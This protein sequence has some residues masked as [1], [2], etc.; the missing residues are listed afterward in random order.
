MASDARPPG[1]VEIGLELRLGGVDVPL[2]E[3]DPF[4]Q[5]EELLRRPPLLLVAQLRHDLVQH[6]VKTVVFRQNLAD[7]ALQLGFLLRD[8]MLAKLPKQV[9]LEDDVGLDHL[10][11]EVHRDSSAQQAAQLLTFFALETF[12]ERLLL[13]LTMARAL[14][15][16]VSFRGSV[17]HPA[18]S[19]AAPFRRVGD[20]AFGPLL[21]GECLPLPRVLLAE[22]LEDLFRERVLLKVSPFGGEPSGTD[23]AERR[24]AGLGG[25][26]EAHANGIGRVGKVEP[27]VLLRALERVHEVPFPD[28]QGAC[29]P[30]LGSAYVRRSEEGA[31]AQHGPDAVGDLRIPD[32]AGDRRVAAL[33]DVVRAG[34]L[35]SERSI[36][37][38]TVAKTDFTRRRGG[39]DNVLEIVGCPRPVGVAAPA[40]GDHL[41][42]RVDVALFVLEH[43]GIQGNPH[44]LALVLQLHLHECLVLDARLHRLLSRLESA[45]PL[46]GQAL[47]VEEHRDG[48]AVGH[49]HVGV[50]LIA[51]PDD[52]LDVLLTKLREAQH[53][54]QGVER[55]LQR[56][57]FGGRV[58]LDHVDPSAVSLLRPGALPGV[59]PR[60]GSLAG[61][62]FLRAHHGLPAIGALVA[63]GTAAVT[64]WD[65]PR[66]AVGGERGGTST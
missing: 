50:T 25:K 66:F 20:Q 57:R 64:C 44:H 4:I 35:E 30:E 52:T 23:R 32:A 48:A 1:V 12:L 33:G 2:D 24:P 65:R 5:L 59:T 51:V 16:A 17:G 63:G 28:E 18:N 40:K 31:G 37:D 49:D 6:G 56:P 62:S 15:G 29:R 55:H 42:G 7:D 9:H 58:R 10:V 46:Q 47:M 36:G 54:E 3:C 19:R 13:G 26:V 27:R 39:H 43:G 53:R 45:A 21:V 22:G 38:R 34:P 8:V 61:A 14:R 11:G 60:H 41:D